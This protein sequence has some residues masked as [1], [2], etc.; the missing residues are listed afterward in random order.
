[1]MSDTTLPSPGGVEIE[2]LSFRR[3]ARPEDYEHLAALIG[4]SNRAEDIPYA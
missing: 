2:G 1:M 3:L 4:A